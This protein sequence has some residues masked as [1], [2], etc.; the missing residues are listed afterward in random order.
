VPPAPF[1]TLTPDLS[2]KTP[3]PGA[4]VT[5]FPLFFGVAPLDALRSQDWLRAAVWVAI[6]LVF[7]R[8]DLLPRRASRA[9]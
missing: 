6:G 9:S 8:G 2:M 3:S 5:V 1:S 7:L 4:D